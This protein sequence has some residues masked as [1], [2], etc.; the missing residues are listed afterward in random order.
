MVLSEDV[1][2]LFHIVRTTLGAPIRPIQIT[3]D[4][5]CDLLTIAIGDYAEK[6]QNWALMV[7]WLNLNG[8]STVSFQN[9]ND[10]VHAMTVRSMDWSRDF[11]YWFSREIGLQ[12]RGNYELQKDFIQIEKGR[13]AYIVPAGRE[14]NKVM[15]VT[16]S[17]TRAAMY[18]SFGMFDAGFGG[19]WG[20]IGN[21][22]SLG[23]GGL[24]TPFMIGTNYDI[25]LLSAD[26]K[27]KNSMFRGDLAYKVT[28]G[29][30]GTHIIHL[31]ST[32]GSPR[33]FGGLALDDNWGW[34]R[35]AGCYVWY[36][37]YDVGEGAS[38]DDVSA[39]MLE[40]RDDVVI[41]PDQVPMSKMR[42]E[43]MNY[44]TQQIVRQLLVAEAKILLGNIR[45]TY[46]GKVQIPEAELN[47]DYQMF[48]EQGKADKEKALND[49]KERL[50]AM[51]P[52]N[53]ISKQ[54]EMMTGMI[55][56]LSKK[57]LGMYWR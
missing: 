14:I 25:A 16:P 46:Q 47:M 21:M 32:P 56:I 12:Q 43:L 49:L 31:M 39:C 22:G 48:I 5:L 20:Q 30:D 35:Y 9:P 53:L 6:V 38:D 11:S 4:Q 37:Y 13:Q 36:T 44:P 45:G 33:N 51:T 54:N 18:G 24:M 27:Y 23:L 3:D 42:Y 34:N 55:D 50:D 29:P 15:Y 7:N 17:T 8:Q 57:P 1:R 2:Q 10:Y 26:M 52:W 41:T 40:N 19:G 28:A